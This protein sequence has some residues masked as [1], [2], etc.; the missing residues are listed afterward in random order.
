MTRIRAAFL[1]LAILAC[2]LAVPGPAAAS[3]RWTP[4]AR[5]VG[6]FQ[7]AA[8]KVPLDYDA[9]HGKKI[10][11]ALVRLPATDQ[12]NRIGSLFLNPGGPGGS[13]VEFLIGLGQQ[14]FTPEV[15]ARFDLIG[16]DPRGIAHSS[17]LRCFN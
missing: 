1:A 4:C 6:P 10:P 17:Q 7:C 15:R 12:A 8:V 11:I 2:G 16:F 14:L 5:G 9:P 13:G 3:V